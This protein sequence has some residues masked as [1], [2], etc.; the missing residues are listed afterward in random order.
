MPG[1]F[2][3]LELSASSGDR[4]ET[5]DIILVSPGREGGPAVVEREHGC[6]CA[7]MRPNDGLDCLYCRAA[8]ES[9]AHLRGNTMCMF[10]AAVPT[11]LSLSLA[12]RHEAAVVVA[13]V[14]YHTH[15]GG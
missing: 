13:E 2:C 7:K 4:T 5:V 3:H 6:N 10:C 8:L 15:L 11:V 12:T 9:R 14:A 1:F